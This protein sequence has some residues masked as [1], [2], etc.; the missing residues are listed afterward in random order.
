M[1]SIIL[2]AIL[3]LIISIY[4][5]IFQKLK[6]QIPIGFL[7]ALI[8]ITY[9]NLPTN[10]NYNRL[11]KGSNVYFKEQNYGEVIAHHE[12]LDGGLTTVH[13][14]HM[15]ND[16][17]TRTLLTNGKFQGNNNTE[18]EVIAQLGFGLVPLLHTKQRNDA[19]VIGYGTGTTTK[20]L[21]EAGFKNMDVVDISNDI[22][23]LANKYFVGINLSFECGPVRKNCGL[24]S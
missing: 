19:L 17:T 6:Q 1:T 7:I 12:S 9:F 14:V 8:I 3:S 15:P 22:F 16:R 18:G 21:Y 20:I 10:L 13:E 2:L 11:A 23:T 24:T 5:T 4:F